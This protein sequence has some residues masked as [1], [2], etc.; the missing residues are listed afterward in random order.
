MGDHRFRILQR[1]KWRQLTLEQAADQLN[2]QPRHV[3]QMA[4]LWGTR[5]DA[6]NLMIDKLQAPLNTKNEQRKIKEKLAVL[7][8]VT[9]RQVNR[10]LKVAN[11][12]IPPP[13]TVEKRSKLRDSAQNRREMHYTHALAA[14]M[15]NTPVIEA[16][17]NAEVSTRQM[18][19]IIDKLCAAV[20]VDYRDL[21]HATLEQ[22]RNVAQLVATNQGLE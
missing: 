17:E 7:M 21:K 2:T 6:M 10:V 18:Y 13:K 8:N 5:L 4:S 16:A 11:V 3:K 1:L 20:E 15:G 9:P 14:I 22:R 12:V 19:R